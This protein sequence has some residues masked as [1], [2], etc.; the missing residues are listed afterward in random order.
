[1]GIWS[2]TISDSTTDTID[3]ATDDSVDAASDTNVNDASNDTI[4]VAA[5]YAVGISSYGAF[6]NAV[7]ICSMADTTTS[8][9][10]VVS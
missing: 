9:P 5:T 8:T 6:T 1:V 7:A 10:G 3:D 4:D 2:R